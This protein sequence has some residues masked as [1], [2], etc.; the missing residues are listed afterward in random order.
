MGSKIKFCGKLLTVG[1]V[2]FVTYFAG[3][4]RKSEFLVLRERYFQNL[5]R[6]V[7]KSI[8][9]YSV[10]AINGEVLEDAGE[11]NPAIN[12]WCVFSDFEDFSHPVISRFLGV[13]QNGCF[14][15]DSYRSYNFC[16]PIDPAT[17]DWNKE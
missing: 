7:I 15:S 6:E 1:N 13:G 16:N 10:E 12:Q 9:V 14:P 11:P 5:A 4:E 3:G 2:Y 8:Q 17:F